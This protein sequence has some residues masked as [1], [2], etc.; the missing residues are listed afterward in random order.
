MAESWA[1]LRSFGKIVQ[2]FR[3]CIVAFWAIAVALGAT[4]AVF[5]IDACV[6]NFDP[7]EGMESFDANA[8]FERLFPDDASSTQW[9][10][11]L[12][13]SPH[14]Q[15]LD[16]ANF[17]KFSASL[18]DDLNSTGQLVSYASAT[19]LGALDPSA[20]QQVVSKNGRTTMIQWATRGR[21]ATESNRDFVATSQ[22]K[23]DKLRAKLL[24][25][26]AFAGITSLSTF[27][28]VAV[29]DA[30]VSLIRMDSVSI[31][32]AFF[33][34]WLMIKSG[35]LLIL[36]AL[37]MLSSLSVSFGIMF[38][39]AQVE[40]VQQTTPSLM[41]SILIAM[42]IDYSL[43]ILTRFR[44][45]LRHTVQ[46]YDNP[47]EAVTEAL[48]HT[49]ETAGFTVLLSCITLTVSFLA[50]IFAPVTV[51]ASLGQGCA[52]A[53]VVSLAVHLT[54]LPAL[55]SCFPVFFS[56]AV[57][58]D[59][60]G[61]KMW[62]FCRSC[63]AKRAPQEPEMIDPEA[64]NATSQ[65][66][67][68]AS[69]AEV[70]MK[71]HH[72]C[73][74][75]LARVT[76][77]FPNNVFII[78]MVVAGTLA[79]GYPVLGFT[80]TASLMLNLPRGSEAART[81]THL[82][83]AFGVGTLTQYQL[84]MEN[85]SGG[86]IFQE[87]FW[88]HTQEILGNMSTSLPSTTPYDL[89]FPSYATD[90]ALPLEVVKPC[91]KNRSA[92]DLC[93]QLGYLLDRFVSADATAMYG[94]INL[95]FD[96]LASNGS[97]WLRE[98]RAFLDKHAEHKG[99]RMSLCGEGSNTFDIS[100]SVYA[101]FPWIIGITLG[102]ALVMLGLAFRSIIIPLRSLA[103][104]ILTL[105]WVYGMA[106]LIYQH[107]ILEWTG[108]PGLTGQ[109]K[110]H[111]WFTPIIA[112]S[113]VC[114]ICLDYDIFLLSRAT[115]LREQGLSPLEAT[116]EALCST[117]GIITAAGVIMA[118]AFF[119]LMFA[120]M[121]VINELSVFLVVAVL[122]DTFIVRSLFSPAMMSLLGRYTWYPSKLAAMD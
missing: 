95:Q 23:F 53:L 6:M 101:F 26:V 85:P 122:Y 87:P 24:P 7:Q 68:V 97:V 121:L 89:T 112:F 38:L 93:P 29:H 69:A 57:S 119:G 116:R 27:I 107:G 99:V 18:L 81:T 3:I 110:A 67:T 82:A 41:M 25:D 79:V 74:V 65:V 48:L 1:A 104:I 78:V 19:T 118:V 30:E 2:R 13:A 76:T 73:L 37:G 62:R 47:R 36:P 70:D 16:Q 39:V 105:L 55:V 11:L 83:D 64:L 17:D 108:I 44:E 40:D 22:H 50:L 56:Y 92:N 80:T 42:C 75:W 117:G 94:Y 35:R 5:F 84:V 12:E 58:E 102:V 63:C 115:E 21:F 88:T 59:R 34:F 14:S 90:V 113:V 77:T 66:S 72:P 54:L 52:V 43:F 111:Y 100:N 91:W 96:P 28:D 32:L 8:H 9:I 120:S 46:K 106:T 71:Q 45:E 4:G 98:A 60:R 103:S 109:Y 15:I 20:V 51:I 31:P 10:G 61:A 114:G 33:V 86:S 49:M